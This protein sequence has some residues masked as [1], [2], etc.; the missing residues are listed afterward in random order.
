[1]KFLEKG[2]LLCWSAVIFCFAFAVTIVIFQDHQSL[3]IPYNRG[4][5][6]EEEVDGPQEKKSEAEIDLDLGPSNFAVVVA[7][8]TPQ[9]N[10][11]VEDKE[12]QQNDDFFNNSTVDE[13]NCD[14]LPLI[15]GNNAWDSNQTSIRHFHT[16]KAEIC[17]PKILIIGAM[18]CGTNTVSRIVVES[19]TWSI[20]SI[21]KF[22]TFS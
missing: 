9:T 17:G 6:P 18:K 16:N 7:T 11:P 5:L 12:T 13:F 14:T 22:Q 3:H 21:C 1:M 15:G 2:C 20:M 10:V 8:K 4:G 19:L